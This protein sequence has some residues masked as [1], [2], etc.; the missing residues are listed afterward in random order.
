ME[1]QSHQNESL[2]PEH[3]VLSEEIVFDLEVENDRLLFEADDDST[4]EQVSLGFSERLQLCHRILEILKDQ[5]NLETTALPAIRLHLFNFL[6]KNPKA[7]SKQIEKEMT[8]LERLSAHERKFAREQNPLPTIG[9]EIEVPQSS[10][11]NE[12]VRILDALQIPNEQEYTMEPLHEVNPNFSYSPWVQGRVIQE[13]A[14][15][16]ALPL[17]KKQDGNNRVIPPTSTGDVLSLHINFG[18]PTGIERLTLHVDYRYKLFLVS[19]L[20]TYAFTTPERVE[21]RKTKT[22]MLIKSSEE[23]GKSK[24]EVD[25]VGP[26]RVEL[27]AMEFRDYPSFRLLG[28]A[29]RLMAMVF[30]NI[31]K[32]DGLPTNIA[33]K[34]FDDVW[35][36]FEKEVKKFFRDRELTQ[37]MVDWS[38][39]KVTQKLRETDLQKACRAIVTKYSKRIGKILR[40]TNE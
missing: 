20:L 35:N 38:P 11:H 32:V 9:I 22:S 12:Q 28:E 27:R 14:S 3:E 15:M 10:L 37:A 16:G 24:K 26:S 19:D 40:E 1:Q 18:V 13:L 5:K 7:S 39:S 33:E 31:K 8:H 23:S 4:E 17:E 25:L 36:D 21:F 29:Q 6:T 34:A 30:A 2:P